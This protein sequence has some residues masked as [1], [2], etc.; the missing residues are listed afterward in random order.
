MSQTILSAENLDIGYSS[1]R[2]QKIYVHKGLDLQLEEGKL[3]CLLGLNG[4][5]KSTLLKTLC[6]F[7]PSLGG[8]IILK[9]R[10][11][12]DYS[13][14]ELSTLT[15][16][17]LTG[18]T[19]DGGL[20]VR[21]LVSMGRYP[22][23]GFFGTLSADDI[24]K[25]DESISAVGIT[26]MSER[27]LA[28]LSD[29]ERQK[30]FI[31]KALAQECPL[32]ILDEPT[33]FLDITSRMEVMALL[34]DIAHKQNI[35]VFLSTHDLDSALQLADMIWLLDKESPIHC[36][37]PKSLASDGTLEAFFSRGSLHFDPESQ[38]I[39]FS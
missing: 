31:A 30:A 22:H 17:V 25:V 32:I 7:I 28:E 13:H 29:G 24:R 6:G 15:G 9:G 23:T 10:P 21:E 16:V 27:H 35:T 37:T 3:T 12:S 33:A 4:A 8:N 2:G 18:R 5:G 14:E 19:S 34:R 20:S 39:I 36:G 38:R 1:G 26:A 11:L